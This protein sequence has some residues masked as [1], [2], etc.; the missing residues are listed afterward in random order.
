MKKP[1]DSTIRNVK[2]S[3]AR[4]KALNARLRRLERFARSWPMTWRKSKG[5][6]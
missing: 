5:Q 2:A 6:S 1:Q 4:D 3:V